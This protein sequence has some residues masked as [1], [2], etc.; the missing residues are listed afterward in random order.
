MKDRNSG[1][2]S[3]NLCHVDE[4]EQLKLPYQLIACIEMP[5]ELKILKD[6]DESYHTISDQVLRISV[7]DLF[8]FLI[9][10]VSSRLREFNSK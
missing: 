6:M 4:I 10:F 8:I 2:F 5:Y 1:L 3:V 9:F 7:L